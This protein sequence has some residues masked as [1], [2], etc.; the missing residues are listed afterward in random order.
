M[1]GNLDPLQINK[2]SALLGIPADFVRKDYFVT[3]VIHALTK[4]NDEYFEL[5]FQGGTSLS[6]GY[7]VIKRMSEDVDFRVTQK[8]KKIT[9]GKEARRKKLRDFRYTLISTLKN[10][11]FAISDEDTRVL[12]EGRFMSIQAKFPDSEKIAYLKPHIAIDCFFSEL[13]LTPITKDITT[14]IKTTLGNEC[15]HLTLPI[16]CIALDE[17]AAEKWVAL[18]R[19]IANTQKKSRLSDKDL[20]RH[21]YDLYQLKTNGLLTGAYTL[22]V[23]KIIEKDKAQFKKLNDAYI[24]NPIRES[25]LALDLLYNDTQW[26]DHWHYFLEQM[27]YDENKPSFNKA[28]MQ[29]KL[30]SDEIFEVLKI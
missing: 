23:H 5:I 19:R 3:Q 28:C 1:Q 11:G 9:L 13:T 14:L 22:L 18:T 15:D 16:S 24:E 6:K 26:K 2:V 21:L 17:T 10:I 27:V 8:S 7:Q 25:A 4:I 29:L 20:V 12:Y 30:L